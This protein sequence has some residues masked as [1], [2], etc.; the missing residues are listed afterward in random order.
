[1]D[2]LTFSLPLVVASALWNRN[3]LDRMLALAGTVAFLLPLR[4]ANLMS[5]VVVL[6]LVHWMKTGKSLLRYMTVFLVLLLA[7]VASQLALVNL[8][9]SDFDEQ[10]GFAVAGSALP[11]VRDLGWT[12]DLLEDERLYGA[13][14]LQALVPLPSFVSNFSQTHSLRAVTSQLI[15]LDAERHTGGLRLTLSGEAFLNFGYFGP[16]GIG[17]L[18]GIACSY[19]RTMVDALAW[20]RTMWSRYL[21]ATILTWV[22]LWIYL[23]GTQSGATIKVGGALMLAALWMSRVRPEP[24]I[25]ATVNA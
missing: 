5:V 18:F 9:G 25:A 12:M 2:L 16:V 11:E 6:V 15:G 4:R 10:T 20:R 17:F 13:T 14:F 1:M 22:C 7:Y 23:S 24:A 21:A 8:L 3:W 19:A